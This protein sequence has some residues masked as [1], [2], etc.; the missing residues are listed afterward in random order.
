MS[1]TAQ[2]TTNENHD[3]LTPM[4]TRSLKKKNINNSELLQL[5]NPDVIRNAKRQYKNLANTLKLT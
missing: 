2:Q 5:L 3:L 4:H 1:F